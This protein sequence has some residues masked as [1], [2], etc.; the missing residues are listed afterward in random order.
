MKVDIIEYYISQTIRL[1]GWLVNR[2]VLDT[3]LLARIPVNK[4]AYSILV[5]LKR[6][7]YNWSDNKMMPINNFVHST[8]FTSV[9]Q[10]DSVILDKGLVYSLNYAINFSWLGISCHHHI[11]CIGAHDHIPRSHTLFLSAVS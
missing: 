8:T 9:H 6:L 3:T 11:M 5:L 1:D 4:T 7:K 2:I 10:H